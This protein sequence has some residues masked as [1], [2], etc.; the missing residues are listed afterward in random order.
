MREC[1]HCGE[2]AL[3]LLPPILWVVLSKWQTVPIIVAI[4]RNGDDDLGA[5]RQGAPHQ[6]LTTCARC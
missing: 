5:L 1:P 3:V 6:A 4:A 2:D